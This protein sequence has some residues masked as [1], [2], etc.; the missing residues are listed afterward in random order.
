MPPYTDDLFSTLKTDHTKIFVLCLRY[1]VETC[2]PISDIK[3]IF[4]KSFHNSF[5]GTTSKTRG[6]FI[7]FAKSILFWYK[8]VFFKHDCFLQDLEFIKQALNLFFKP[9]TIFYFLHSSDQ[10]FKISELFCIQ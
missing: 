8:Y 2:V 1:S 7:Y 4:T 10:T 5:S 3:H 6:W 9:N